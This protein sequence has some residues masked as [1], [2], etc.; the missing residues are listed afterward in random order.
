[1]G[2]NPG[3]HLERPSSSEVNFSL[4]KYAPYLLVRGVGMLDFVA[5]WKMG[6]SGA[7]PMDFATAVANSLTV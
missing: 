3:G 4:A 7:T 5:S 1:M 2:F 6:D